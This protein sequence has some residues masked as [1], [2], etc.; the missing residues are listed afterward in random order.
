[1]AALFFDSSALIKRYIVET[2]TEWVIELLRPSIANDVFIANITGIEVASAIARRLRSGSLDQITAKESLTRFKRDFDKRFIVIDLTEKIINEGFSLAE[3]HGL[4]GYD[5]AQLAVGV[6]VMNRLKQSGI[7]DFKFISAD[8]D[9]NK[10]AKAEG[11]TVENPID[12][13]L[14]TN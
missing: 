3:K 10:A 5:T 2:G 7:R 8:N 11:L 9:L 12:H 6:S 1:M 14:T 4:R 13:S